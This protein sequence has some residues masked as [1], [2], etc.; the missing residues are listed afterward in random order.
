[1]RLGTSLVPDRQDRQA[2]PLFPDVEI[3]PGIVVVERRRRAL[4][5]LFGWIADTFIA[6]LAH[7]AIAENPGWAWAPTDAAAGRETGQGYRPAAAGA[8]A[9]AQTSAPYRRRSNLSA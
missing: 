8:T 4:P 6:G 3:R 9:S 5:A 1:M 2:H 7:Y